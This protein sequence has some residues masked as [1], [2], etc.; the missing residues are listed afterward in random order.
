MDV[1]S[2]PV[3]MALIATY[4]EMSKI[5]LHMAEKKGG[6]IAYDEYASFNDAVAAAKR[7][8]PEVD[9]ILSRGGT[10]EYIQKNVSIPV[11]F[12][13]ITP[14]DVV[15][16]MQKVDRNVGEVALSNFSRRIFGV[17][18]IQK[19][20]GITIHEYIF[21]DRDD[22]EANILD[23]KA[24]GIRVVI[25][26]EV[27]VRIA[28]KNGLDGIDL[29]AGNDTVNRAVDEAVSIVRAARQ[30]R[31]RAT[32]LTAAL[33][34]ITEGLVVTDEN[35]N[36]LI[37]NPA[38]TKMLGGH[39]G[40]GK[41]YIAPYP[42]ADLQKAA[43]APQLNRM[44]KIGEV[45]ANINL[46]PVT[47]GD[48]FIGIVHTF[49]DV[50]KIQQLEQDIRNQLHAKGF[51]AK[52]RFEDIVT[53]DHQMT[54]LKKSAALYAKTDSAIM[55]EGESGTGKELFAQSIHNASNRAGGPF[56][57]INCAA[58][59]ESILESELF[60][61]EAGAFTGA[62]KEGRRGLFEM[63]HRG[64]IF[65]DEIG[66]IP[67]QLQT[68]LL[69]VLQEKELM[70]VGGGR[71][72]PIDTRIISATNRNLRELVE[73]GDFRDDLYYRLAV[74]QLSPPSLRHRRGDIEM[75]CRL[76]LARMNVDMDEAAFRKF[77]P[78]LLAY[79]WPGN[80]RELQNVAERMSLLMTHALYEDLQ[81]SIDALGLNGKEG[82]TGLALNVDVSQG[83][84][85]AIE[86]VERDIIGHMLR[87]N[88]NNNNAVA[89]A[90]GIGRSTLWRKY[91]QEEPPGEDS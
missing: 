23:A 64:T 58:I 81:D 85:T 38:A 19:I 36:L 65:L 15:M 44:R 84:K 35:N 53:N 12:I 24:K 72:I 25:G 40:I 2:Q 87:M 61:Y 68:R 30:E 47:M 41:P 34:S 50:T 46:L 71:I 27:A 33:N 31:D 55:I 54:V 13:P 73:K 49:E 69:R 43:T 70:R 82:R 16:A 21:S 63:A 18:E 91:A 20:Y 22:I 28:L 86:Q 56:V 29:S 60:G 11:V 10:A 76:F 66:E 32:R 80:I 4:P 75:L 1:G 83:L 14:F 6:I 88:N 39:C 89:K 78:A 42:D 62:K 37:C 77:L 48:R 52:Y 90:L 51:V 59:P 5:F 17:E 8:E 74:L 7:L 57:A 79:H 9:V 67:K 26:G 45:M 3:K